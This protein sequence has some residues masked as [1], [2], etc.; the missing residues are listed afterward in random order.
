LLS[1]VTLAQVSTIHYPFGIS[2]ARYKDLTQKKFS[3]DSIFSVN[4]IEE[5]SENVIAANVSCNI[6]YSNSGQ[7]KSYSPD[8]KTW[9]IK[10]HV[11]GANEISVLL[12]DVKLKAGEKL[13]VYNTSG[14][15]GNFDTSNTPE[16]G[17]IPINYLRGNEIVIEFD[18]PVQQTELG[19]FLIKLISV[20]PSHDFR[21]SQNR[22]KQNTGALSCYTCVNGDFWDNSKK[23]VVKI[24]TFRVNS[25]I[26][27]T[28]TL[29]NNSAG[30]ARPYILTAQHC[31]TNQSEADNS[32]FTFRH[33]DLNCDGTPLV[34]SSIIGA[35]LRASSYENDFS[36][37][38]LY[39]HV[40][41]GMQPYFS[42]WD[43]SDSNLDQ[44]SCIHHPL[45]GV[46]KISVYNNS[47]TVSDFVVEKSNPRATN[48]FWH[49]KKWDAG[50]T[51]GGSSGGPLFNRQQQIIGTLSGGNSMCQYPYDDYFQRL[52][53]SW[54][55]NHDPSHQL[56]HWLDPRASGTRSLNGLS[57]FSTSVVS[58]DSILNIDRNEFSSVVHYDQGSG[59]LGGCNSDSIAAYAE[60]FYY[61][62]SAM[63]TGV[64]LYVGSLNKT[65]VGGIMMSVL[66][67]KNGTPGAAIYNQYI[68]YH[69]LRLHFNYIEFYPYV[70]V[71][72]KFFISYS[73]DCSSENDFALDLAFWRTSGSNTAWMKLDTGWIPMNKIRPD[74]SGSSLYIEALVCHN[75]KKSFGSED[76]LINLYPN[77]SS[78]LLICSVVNSGNSDLEAV[79]YNTQ[80]YEQYANIAR[81][82]NDFMIDVTRLN[83]GVYILLIRSSTGRYYRRFVRN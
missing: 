7:W 2:S 79:I 18:V 81:Y 9:L 40:P 55:F 28:G 20:V 11:D 25:S 45:G 63:I 42:G 54:D 30:D 27:C 50:F 16:S 24:T 62:D 68:P 67:D 61:A 1:Q 57:P 36:L 60:A 44:L 10:I 75:E 80:G 59:L 64:Q 33:D 12:T 35:Q 32:I 4:N 71:P 72:G 15:T 23:S 47:V 21:N 13:F 17:I 53:K 19:N 51:E 38:E 73:P 78:S 48:A 49:V 77:P 14:V 34:S 43:I 5:Q 74:G 39:H 69:K 82:N 83:R 66:A 6:H 56:K 22:A 70:D 31:I 58:C 3:F 8:Y 46:K 76:L 26:V 65:A 37:V 52:S 41:L 29:V